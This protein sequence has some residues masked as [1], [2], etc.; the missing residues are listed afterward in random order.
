MYLFVQLNI[1]SFA[2]YK[3]S[4]FIRQLNFASYENLYSLHT[5]GAFNLINFLARSSKFLTKI[6][7]HS[8]TELMTTPTQVLEWDIVVFCFVF[9]P[10]P[11]LSNGNLISKFK[12]ETLFS[13]S[14]PCGTLCWQCMRYIEQHWTENWI[15]IIFMLCCSNIV[16]TLAS[17]RYQ[18][19]LPLT[20]N[21]F[22][23]L[24]LYNTL[25]AWFCFFFFFNNPHW[26]F[27]GTEQDL[28][29]KS[30]Y[31]WNLSLIMAQIIPFDFCHGEG[32]N[33]SKPLGCLKIHWYSGLGLSDVIFYCF[34]LIFCLSPF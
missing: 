25:L 23:H 14:F 5:N 13:K 15:N 22:S 16:H 2:L 3:C 7:C 4:L 9:F 1:Y 26:P 32:D 10:T 28:I 34:L 30:K 21:E 18:N 33:D 11:K 24:L 17:T 27:K 31:F 12:G 8:K 6:F 19:K 29:A 20:H